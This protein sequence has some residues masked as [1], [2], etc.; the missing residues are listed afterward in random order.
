[1]KIMLSLLM[2]L[3]LLVSCSSQKESENISN[4]T[5]VDE[6]TIADTDSLAQIL[7]TW[8]PEVPV[9]SVKHQW[10]VE[11][12]EDWEDSLFWNEI[13]FITQS[14]SLHHFYG[15][16]ADACI[17][18]IF[19]N[20]NGLRFTWSD[21]LGLKKYTQ[22]LSLFAG[23]PVSTERFDA[24]YNSKGLENKS[25]DSTRFAK[26]CAEKNAQLK[27]EKSYEKELH[28]RCISVVDTVVDA[29]D[30]LYING[31]KLKSYCESMEKN[32]EKF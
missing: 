3:L 28:L 16:D 15:N 26:H 8:V 17:I 29:R 6:N 14:E 25:T 2:A 22:L 13:I 30:Y 4:G 11:G 21:S 10:D 23:T 31:E 5:V 12:V 1:M 9:D 7:Q 19:E 18:Q 24:L 27:I 20:E 32:Y